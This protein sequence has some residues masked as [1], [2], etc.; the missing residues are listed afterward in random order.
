MP[1]ELRKHEMLMNSLHLDVSMRKTVPAARAKAAE[2]GA[3][4]AAIELPDG[5][6]HRQD[7]GGLRVRPAPPCS[8]PSSSPP[9]S[10]TA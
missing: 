9:G 10:T 6:R 5:Y 8:M 3:P 4:A 7:L 1:E 2:T